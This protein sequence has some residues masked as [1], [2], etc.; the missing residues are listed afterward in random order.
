MHILAFKLHNIQQCRLSMWMDSDDSVVWRSNDCKML[1]NSSVRNLG[2]CAVY[3]IGRLNSQIV[4]PL[5]RA[6]WNQ[7][8]KPH[9]FERL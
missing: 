6:T 4:V 8:S 7:T 1:I 9:H 2:I 5:E 3:G